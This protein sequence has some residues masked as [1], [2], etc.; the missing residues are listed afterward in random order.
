MVETE[1]SLQSMVTSEMVETEEEE[2]APNNDFCF[3]EEDFIATQTELNDATRHIASRRKA[4]NEI[5]A[6]KGKVVCCNNAKDGKCEWTV[7]ENV[8]ED[9]F[10]S[11]QKQEEELYKTEY[12]AVLDEDDDF[13]E[14][15]Y[16]NSFWF[17]W[18]ETIDN[19][20]EK[21]NKI[22]ENSNVKQKENYQ[23]P[24]QVVSK[25]EFITFHALLVAAAAYS[26]KGDKLWPS[27][28]VHTSKKRQGL[29]MNVDFGEHMKQ[30]RFR[31]VM[32]YIAQV[33][34]HHK[35]RET[36]DWWKFKREGQ[37]I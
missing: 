22:I 15:S 19:N 5:K 34:E 10:E 21:L 32:N 29:L 20:L 14:E 1:D 2:V 13:W 9:V 17:L 26:S 7:V 3:T 33:M 12:C 30:W 11:V 16:N 18:P 31:Q 37:F 35:I 4:W 6:M 8:T 23:R 25:R 27:K 36:D 28:Y 24:I